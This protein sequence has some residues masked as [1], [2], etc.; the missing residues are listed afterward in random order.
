MEF[1]EVG[2]G[3]FIILTSIV[4]VAFANTSSSRDDTRDEVELQETVTVDQTLANKKLIQGNLKDGL[5]YADGGKTQ[6]IILTEIDAITGIGLSANK[7]SNARGLFTAKT[8]AN[9]PAS[10]VQNLDISSKTISSS[11]GN[12]FVSIGFEGSRERNKQTEQHI[13]V[14]VDAINSGDGQLIGPRDYIQQ[15]FIANGAFLVYDGKQ[16]ITGKINKLTTSA[17]GRGVGFLLYNSANSQ[18]NYAQQIFEGE[19]GEIGSLEVPFNYGIRAYRGGHQII[20]KVGSVYGVSAAIDATLND[21]WDSL[22]LIKSVDTV[23]SHNTQSSNGTY[24]SYG[25]QNWSDVGNHDYIGSQVVG[26]T[27]KISA[28]SQYGQAIAIHNKGGNQTIQ[29]LSKYDPNNGKYGVEVS[30]IAKQSPVGLRVRPRLYDDEHYVKTTTALEGPFYFTDSS[31]QV[32]PPTNATTG[33][34]VTYGNS[35]LWFKANPY[36]SVL[37]LSPKQGIIIQKGSN[38]DNTNTWLRLGERDKPYT[39]RMTADNYINDSGM[40]AGNGSIRFEAAYLSDNHVLS[41]NQPNIKEPDPNKPD[42]SS[43]DDYVLSKNHG[44][45]GRNLTK[46]QSSVQTEKKLDINFKGLLSSVADR[47]Q[48]TAQES[49]TNPNEPIE[50]EEPKPHPYIDYKYPYGINGPYAKYWAVGG[51]TG[52]APYVYL[53]KIDTIDGNPIAA[54]RSNASSLNLVVKAYVYENGKNTGVLINSDNFC[55]GGRCEGKDHVPGWPG[56]RDDAKLASAFWLLRSVANS[57]FANE[58]V[59]NMGSQDYILIK[60]DYKEGL[61]GLSK[62]TKWH[63]LSDEH[64][65]QLKDENGQPIIRRWDPNDPKAE[66]AR[67]AGW[68]YLPEGVVN[69][70]YKAQWY[71]EDSELVA[72]TA[73]SIKEYEALHLPKDVKYRGEIIDLATS[74]PWEPLEPGFTH[75]KPLFPATPIP[76]PEPTP[77]MKSIESISLSHYFTWRQEI[78][79]LHQRLGEV[80]DN[81]ELEGLWARGYAGRNRLSHNGYSFK[82]NYRG[83]QIGLDRNYY[84]YKESYRC[85]D[86]DGENFPCKREKAHDWTYGTGVSYTEGDLKLSRGGNGDNWMASLWLYGIRKFS[87]GGYL[88]LVGKVSRFSNKF[89]AWSSDY[90]LNTKGRDKTWGYT[91]SAEYGNKHYIFNSKDWYFDP[92]LQIV[93]GRILGSSFRTNNDVNVDHRRIDSLIGRAG[94]ALGYDG[95]KGSAFVKVDGLREFKGRFDTNYSLDDG[96]SNRSRFNLRETWGEIS[97]GGTYTFSKKKDKFAHFYVK[98]SLSSKLKTDYR[99]DVGIEYI[100]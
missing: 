68:V 77:T 48:P 41:E 63:I 6:K 21:V 20:D 26:V 12:V 96:T 10:T 99:V 27:E 15:G 8:I 84:E 90:L 11:N 23:V 61:N 70:S 79:T 19:I 89:S 97:A 4:S 28:Y 62:G 43:P 18:A 88:D 52:Q 80:R 39:V 85:R 86:K 72:E 65:N 94:V 24:F 92:Q 51:K 31:L 44:Y 14:S 7:G 53:N 78:D 1:A 38:E 82:D 42:P 87:N 58:G 55:S 5:Y 22:Q 71:F 30:A 33:R 17:P 32:M 29:S 9:A 75:P 73:T 64:G 66:L 45:E 83:I 2:G 25:I 50:P 16:K 93:Y 95:K 40:F 60:D 37:S 34:P 35:E 36:G 59:E 56:S 76:K 46:S 91:L 67:P 69:N 13:T 100:F 98:R 74:I 57:I 49:P 54:D 3:V 47:D 81:Y